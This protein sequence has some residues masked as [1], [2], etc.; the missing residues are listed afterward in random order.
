MSTTSF[1]GQ[2]LSSP[3]I[4]VSIRGCYSSDAWIRNFIF[5]E[6]NIENNRVLPKNMPGML[7]VYHWNVLL[8]LF[9]E[10]IFSI[11]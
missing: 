8:T 11:L 4:A 7:E 3:K 10:K 9:L 2:N 1:Y 5:T 6:Q